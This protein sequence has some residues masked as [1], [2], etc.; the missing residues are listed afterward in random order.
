MVTPV[1]PEDRESS[2]PVENDDR[3][4]SDSPEQ[5]RPNV[6]PDAPGASLVDPTI[7]E[8]AEPNEPG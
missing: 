6:D 1:E 4:G 2:D 3:E 8:P 5:P 7:E